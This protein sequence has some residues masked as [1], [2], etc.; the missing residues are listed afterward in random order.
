M[1]LPWPAAQESIDEKIRPFFHPWYQKSDNKSD[2]YQKLEFFGES[3]QIFILYILIS[4]VWVG[5]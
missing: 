1:D 5:S 3:E 2:K 4:L